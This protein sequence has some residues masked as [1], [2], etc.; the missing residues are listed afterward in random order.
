MHYTV[1][2]LNWY[3]YR[4]PMVGGST[5]IFKESAEMYVFLACFLQHFWGYVYV[6]SKFVAQS[7]TMHV[8][9]NKN[10]CIGSTEYI[11]VLFF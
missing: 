7:T 9:P 4:L 5:A 10:C 3:P 8:L 2:V 1:L 6:C 11:S